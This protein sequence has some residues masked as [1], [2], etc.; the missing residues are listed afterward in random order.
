MSY[1]QCSRIEAKRYMKSAERRRL[2][3]KY[4][5]RSMIVSMLIGVMIGVVL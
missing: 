1:I 2:K 4:F 5:Y 3:V